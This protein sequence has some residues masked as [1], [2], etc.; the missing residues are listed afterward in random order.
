MAYTIQK[1]DTLSKIARQNNMTIDEILKLNPYITDPNKIRAGKEINL[2]TDTMYRIP[3]TT[4]PVPI[5]SNTPNTPSTEMPTNP[6]DRILRDI[7]EGYK[8]STEAHQ[9]KLDA[10]LG[11][12]EA[13]KATIGQ[14][15]YDNT[16]A[17]NANYANTQRLLPEQMARLGLYGTGASETSLINTGNAYRGLLGD[18]NLSKTQGLQ[19]IDTQKRNIQSEAQS[20]ISD[21]YANYINQRSNILLQGE[22]QRI[23]QEER[24]RQEKLARDEMAQRERLSR[25]TPPKATI[26]DE[27]SSDIGLGG[28]TS[29]T[30]GAPSPL[31]LGQGIKEQDT[32]LANQKTYGAQYIYD[33]YNTGKI[34][35]AEAL[36]LLRT[37]PF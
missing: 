1:G 16:R 22:Q 4:S 20:V 10:L 29:I 12:L 27:I 11:E 19:A 8:K 32:H 9:S 33:L 26:T 2:T 35:E 37:M 25:T 34:T 3:E 7:D 28:G 14:Q 6:Y 24:D 5:G 31:T 30:S 13:G 21:A 23:A 17:V 18:V 36:E 15:A